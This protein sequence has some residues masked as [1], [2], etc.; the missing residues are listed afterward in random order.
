V[1]AE[2]FKGWNVSPSHYIGQ[3]LAEVWL[4]E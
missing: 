4:Q 1:T 3:D 2:N